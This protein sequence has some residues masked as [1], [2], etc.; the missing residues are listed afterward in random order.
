ME[1]IDPE[2]DSSNEEQLT[3][4]LRTISYIEQYLSE[5]DFA[6]Y[7]FAD[8]KSVCLAR[9]VNMRKF[10]DEAFIILVRK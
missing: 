4:H 2:A 1:L 8:V 5:D 6:C 9:F 10:E 7:Q 3:N